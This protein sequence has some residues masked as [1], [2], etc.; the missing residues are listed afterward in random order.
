MTAL[1][2][3]MKEMPVAF[4]FLATEIFELIRKSSIFIRDSVLVRILVESF[5]IDDSTAI[6]NVTEV[7]KLIS[8]LRAEQEIDCR[9]YE[10]VDKSLYE[11][12]SSS[13]VI[14]VVIHGPPSDP[15]MS[16]SETCP[17]M[18]SNPIAPQ[19]PCANTDLSSSQKLDVLLNAHEIIAVPAHKET[20]DESRSIMKTVASNGAHHSRTKVPDESAYWGPLVV[21][22]DMSYLNDSHAFDQISYKSE[23]YLS[24]ASNDGQEPN[25]M[26]IDADYSSGQL[27]FN[28]IFKKFDDNV[29][30][31]SSFN[32]LI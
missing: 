26:L 11:S 19:T 23:E 29:S 15:E 25:E 2:A 16:I 12:L 7:D 4:K 22:P 14:E 13:N 24:D 20:E 30:E 9:T 6:N 3:S 10:C 28:E 18:G 1:D 32:D 5:S 8:N 17:V 27:S 31:K 21:L